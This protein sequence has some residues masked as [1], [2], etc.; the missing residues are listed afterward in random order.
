MTLNSN[1]ELL[2]DSVNLSSFPLNVVFSPRTRRIN[3]GKTYN[4][5]FQKFYG[6]KKRNK[7]MVNL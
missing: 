5:C 6:S 7:V 3:D 4:S 1:L 2:F